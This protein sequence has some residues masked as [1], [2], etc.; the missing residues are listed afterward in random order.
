MTEE[1]PRPDLRFDPEA[2]AFAD[3]T[4]AFDTFS[5]WGERGQ[6]RLRGRRFFRC[7]LVGPALVVLGGTGNGFA[8]CIFSGCS[9]TVAPDEAPIEGAIRLED[10][11][12]DD[13]VLTRWA[14]FVPPLVAAAMMRD[15][16]QAR[17]LGLPAAF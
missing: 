11:A 5:R 12:F 1:D 7:N 16:P 3:L 17:F 10:C 2:A 14:C 8:D 15:M 4:L 9:F 6:T 13:C